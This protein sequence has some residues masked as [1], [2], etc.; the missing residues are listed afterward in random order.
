M[1]WSAV[2]KA[3]DMNEL[4]ALLKAGMAVDSIIN[5]EEPA[6]TCMTALF[7]YCRHGNTAAVKLLLTAGAAP[8]VMTY[9]S[10]RGHRDADD[11]SPLTVVAGSGHTQIVGLLLKAGADIYGGTFVT[12][13][14]M[15]CEG[16]KSET[17]RVLLE[18]GADVDKAA[19]D[20]FESENNWTPLFTA[21]QIDD[22][23]A[24]LAVV[25]LLLRHGANLERHDSSN[26]WTPLLL[27]ANFGYANIVKELCLHGARR[28]PVGS[29]DTATS[30]S[31]N[32]RA[33]SVT[34][35]LE[36]TDAPDTSFSPLRHLELLS[37]SQAKALLRAGAI[38]T[39]ATV[40]DEARRLLRQ[41]ATGLARPGFEAAQVVAA[42]CM[43][44]SPASHALWPCDARQR[45]CEILEA[46]YHLAY[47]RRELQG[48][49]IYGNEAAGLKDVMRSAVITHALERADFER[50][51]RG[52]GVAAALASAQV[53]WDTVEPAVAALATEW[54]DQVVPQ[55]EQ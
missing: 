17:V 48:D 37:A 1:S 13:L 2:V 15:A 8:N 7:Y 24:N 31:R 29:D 12:P 50:V 52:A 21:C 41:A 43:P 23:A 11:L 38:A 46:I 16:G 3:S 34:E 32:D 9:G 25:R 36:R 53:A 49:L 5:F 54:L 4:S 27:A 42:A 39:D 26:A 44:W 20:G 55:P 22:G 18:A 10:K 19:A 14:Y 30:A 40:Q 51:L 33:H 6:R 47:Q 45:S 35:W 28:A